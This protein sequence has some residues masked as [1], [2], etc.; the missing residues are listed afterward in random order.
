MLLLVELG[1]VEV[2]VVDALVVADPICR[3]PGMFTLSGTFSDSPPNWSPMPALAVDG[4]S[5]GLGDGDGAAVAA[6]AGIR[7]SDSAAPTSATHRRTVRTSVCLT[8]RM[9]P[10]RS[11][12]FSRRLHTEPSTKG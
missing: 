10:L 3:I 7:S 1:G 11:S 4:D 12:R 6:M 2:G 5:D 8:R 9:S